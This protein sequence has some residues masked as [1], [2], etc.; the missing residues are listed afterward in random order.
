MENIELQDRIDSLSK[1]KK[2]LFEYLKGKRKSDGIEHPI[3]KFGLLSQKDR[4]LVPEGVENAYPLSRLQMGMLY[5]MILDGRGEGPSDYHNLTSFECKFKQSFCFEYLK[6][7]VE[8]VVKAHENLRVSFDLDSFSVPMQL[9]H[10]NVEAKVYYHDIRNESFLDKNNTIKK[11]IMSENRNDF[12][13]RDPSLIRFNV[14]HLESNVIRF[15][16]SEPH[17]ISDGWSTIQTMVDIFKGYFCRTR[18][19]VYPCLAPKFG[20]GDYIKKELEMLSSVS[21]HSFWD[22]KITICI[23]TKLP[24]MKAEIKSSTDGDGTLK[25]KKPLHQDV[26]NGLYRISIE[27]GVSLKSLFIAAHCK[28]LSFITGQKIVTTGMATNGRLESDGGVN[29]RGLFL[30]TL[31]LTVELRSCTWEELVDDIFFSEKE[32]LEY[33][34]FPI[35]EIQKKYGKDPIFSTH[36]GFLHFRSMSETLLSGDIEITKSLDSSNTNFDY[37]VVFYVDPENKNKIDV[38]I[39]ANASVVSNQQFDRY[40]KYLQNIL[41]D[42]CN[43]YYGSHDSN[44]YLTRSESYDIF[45]CS[46]G[47][48]NLRFRCESIPEV[49]S[50]IA[51]KNRN[52]TAVSHG[53]ISLSYLGLDGEST[54]LAHNLISLGVKPG[55]RVGVCFDRSISTIVAFLAI[56][57]CGAAYVPISPVNPESRTKYLIDDSSINYVVTDPVYE[58]RYLELVGS[59]CLYQLP[60]NRE[61]IECK[62]EQLHKQFALVLPDMPAYVIYTSG[63]TGYPK[64]VQVSHSNIISLLN[65]RDFLEVNETDVVAQVSNESFDAATY[66]IW[67]GLLAGGSVVICNKEDVLS[68]ETFEK[69][70]ENEKISVMF[71]TTALFNRMLDVN[72]KIFKNLRKLLFGGEKYSENALHTMFHSGGEPKEL[73]HVYG[74]T[75]C[76]TFST[77]FIVDKDAYILGGG[78]PIGRAISGNSVYVFDEKLNFSPY[79]ALG[80]IY[81]SGD[82]V[83]LGYLGDKPEDNRR[84]M[85]DPFYPGTERS[86]YQSGD[87]GRLLPSGDVDFVG[88]KDSQVKIR[89]FRV[90]LGEIKAS[91]DSLEFV[92]QSVVLAKKG[93]G[94]EK[95][96]VAY[97]SPTKNIEVP[98]SQR[99]IRGL[100]SDRLPYY[101]V[102]EFI[103]VLESF[104]MTENGKIDS[105]KLPDYKNTMDDENIFIEPTTDVEKVVCEICEDVLGVNRVGVG[106]NFFHIGGHSLHGTRVVSKLNGRFGVKLPLS[107]I[108]TSDNLLEYSAL[109]DKRLAANNAQ[110]SRRIFPCDRKEALHVSAAQKRLWFIDRL[111]NGSSQYNISFTM[112]VTGNLNIKY[113]ERAFSEIIRRHEILRTVIVD[114]GGVAFQKVKGSTEFGIK[115][116][117]ASGMEKEQLGDLIHSESTELFDL[118]NDLNIR[119]SL[120]IR[121]AEE[122]ILL[123]TMHHI[124]SDGWSIGILVKELSHLYSALVEG[125]QYNLPDL[126]IQYVDYASW[127]RNWMQGEVLDESLDYWQNHLADIPVAHSIPLDRPRP[128]KQSFN[129]AVVLGNVSKNISERLKKLCDENNATVFMGLHAVFSVLLARYS[130]ESDIVIGSPIANREHDEIAELIGFFVNTLVL[131]ADLSGSPSFVDLLLQCKQTDLMAYAHQQLPFEKI[132]EILQPDR[133]T[134]HSPIFQI[135]LALQNND[136]CDLELPG[137]KMKFLEGKNN[138][139]KYD[140]TLNIHEIDSAYRLSWEYNTDIFDRG[141][142]GHMSEYFTWLLD[143]LVRTPNVNVFDE[144]FIGKYKASK[145]FVPLSISTYD[146]YPSP[147]KRE[148]DRES[149]VASIT[150]NPIQRHSLPKTDT[151]CLLCE[152]VGEL[153]FLDKVVISDNL[154]SLGGHSF[155]V[156]SLHARLREEGFSVSVKDIYEASDLRSLADVLD[157][158]VLE[159][160]HINSQI[161]SLIPPDCKRITPEMLD[162][163][164]LT[165]DVIDGIGLEVTGGVGN[166]QDIYPLSPLQE[167]ILFQ[168]NLNSGKDDPYILTTLLTITGKGLLTR[169]IASLEKSVD[170]HDVLRTGFYGNG[171]SESLQ[172]VQRDAKL[173]VR[174]LVV[175]NEDGILSVVEEQKVELSTAMNVEEPPLIRVSVVCCHGSDSYYIVLCHHHLI[176]DHVAQELLI[177]DLLQM[178]RNDNEALE[179]YTPYRYFIAQVIRQQDQLDF[180]KYFNEKLGDIDETTFP[181]GL[182]DVY[183]DRNRILEEDRLL[184]VDLTSKIR[185]FSK[186]HMVSP[187]V[188][189]H[190][191]YAMLLGLCSGKKDVIFGTV[192]SGRLSGAH[193]SQKIMGMAINTLPIRIC[194]CDLG[195]IE[196]LERVKDEIESLLP[197]EQTPLS[198][199]QEAV[200]L[201]GGSPL[202][203]ALLNYRHSSNPDSRDATGVGDDIEVLDSHERT[204][205]P[206]YVSVDDTSTGFRLNAQVVKDISPSRILNYFENSLDLLIDCVN[207]GQEIS[208]NNLSLYSKKEYDYLVKDMN[209]TQVEYSGNVSFQDVINDSFRMYSE[210]IAVEYGDVQL[211]Y[212]ELNEKIK[213]ISSYLKLAFKTKE[214]LKIG[215]SINRSVDMLVAILAVLRSNASYVPIDPE[216]PKKRIEYILDN[217]GID[218]VLTTKDVLKS[219]SFGES[220]AVCVDDDAIESAIKNAS[221]N[222]S[223]ECKYYSDDLAY[224]IYTS[225]STGN[226]KGVEVENRSLINFLNS[227]SSK[228]EIDKTDRVL[229]LSSISFDISILELF[230]PLMHGATVVIATDTAIRCGKEISNIVRSKD[231]TTM[232][233]TPATW[234]MIRNSGSIPRLRNAI[235]GGDKLEDDDARWMLANVE[236]L[237]HV[238]G[239]TEATVWSTINRV[240][241]DFESLSL[242]KPIWNVRLYVVSSDFDVLPADVPG[243]LLIAGDGLSRGYAGQPK[244]SAEKFIRGVESIPESV[245]YRTGDLV[246]WNS[247]GELLFLGRLD[248]QVKIRGYRIEIGEIENNIK[249]Y[250]DIEATAVVVQSDS[251]G[252]QKIVAFVTFVDGFKIENK[253][254]IS[255]KLRTHLSGYLPFYMIPNIYIALEELPLTP[256]KKVDRKYLSNRNDYLVTANYVAPSTVRQKRLA[257]IWEELLDIDNIGLD[258]NFF[259]IGA[260][261]VSLTKFVAI[262]K[263]ELSVDLALDI[264]F[265]SPSIRDVDMHIET[266]QL[267]Q[268]NEELHCMEGATEELI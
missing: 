238:Y 174:T 197:F 263:S 126:P 19:E 155:T 224:T 194:L 97:L 56:L 71:V 93:T 226:P 219:T 186:V 119:S 142:I 233:A 39:E 166:I 41:L 48:Q 88:R 229:A 159:K 185:T 53:E 170:R 171:G 230:L 241:N 225:G 183:V 28:F 116:F 240:S 201:S 165:Q 82:S 206:L 143:A 235:V 6:Q 203:V 239:P 78:V 113:L 64:G 244:L 190:A 55:D 181:F 44:R 40:E 31:P 77:A 101:M 208:S 46:Y 124:A 54:S 243:E 22:K 84:F 132:V 145:Q 250:P 188:I 198:Q 127:Q 102:P 136:R 11:F 12:D 184:S 153:L 228:L 8:D 73:V 23:P 255:D 60:D 212:G 256:N 128:K 14:H 248:N 43:N 61:K 179:K 169:F 213:K 163:V 151:E 175:D 3:A 114:D 80:E 173:F 214:P 216:Y 265:S 162:L 167:G 200:G 211:T 130:G 192:L 95:V 144:S 138:Y 131:R 17:S 47:E 266:L 249:K 176:L 267:I 180:R 104:P 120:F 24:V 18:N 25:I 35:Q 45:S 59:I 85:I 234:S 63:S 182:T 81:I 161:K 70:V 58:E 34:R 122:N 251:F 74:P 118:S 68:P 90:E 72:P 57:K 117:D 199:I 83:S 172:V 148:V 105:K 222:H 209:D 99:S 16:F 76:T 221:G 260:N 187:A 21:A 69:F 96:L 20:Y 94:G 177:S 42:L 9:V 89:G 110:S 111:G 50:E 29:M 157:D 193:S 51:S 2:K 38:F 135:M 232:Q 100:L 10:K 246:K 134:S 106:D 1:D 253:K 154:F 123:V 65:D 129:G 259:Y 27:H 223:L 112:S 168:S 257:K 196:Y 268:T 52:K 4:L 247:S 158:L 205:F 139:S 33:R 195:R 86:M 140:I 13:T 217:S 66:E 215:V 191:A 7:S 103:V 141:T 236:R 146:S 87:L 261:S 79:G 262:V 178:I 231:I 242:G 207:S 147:L 245:L 5:H 121:G 152:I 202:F 218:I 149:L 36:I 15:S 160:Q 254:S 164:D 220:F 107:E 62:D 264:V 30:N 210:N 137:L 32:L 189:F 258:D 37:S 67:G 133:S 91:L 109:I 237:W 92:Y 75:E 156:M 204:N 125:H 49:F 252:E 150:E 26:V 98:V 227:F 115:I 108:F